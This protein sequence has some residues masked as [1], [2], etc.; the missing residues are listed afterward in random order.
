MIEIRFLKKGMSFIFDKKNCKVVF[1]G[2]DIIVFEKKDGLHLNNLSNYTKSDL[3]HLDPNK[4]YDGWEGPFDFEEEIEITC[5]KN[6]KLNQKLYKNI[7]TG[8]D[9]EYIHY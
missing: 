3:T 8:E 9:D 7:K 6:N 5:V 2:E 1:V 4:S